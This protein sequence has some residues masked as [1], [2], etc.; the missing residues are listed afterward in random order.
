MFYAYY[1]SYIEYRIKN[2]TV[3]FLSLRFCTA[4]INLK[5]LYKGKFFN[6]KHKEHAI[7]RSIPFPGKLG[8]VIHPPICQ[9]L[10][11]GSTPL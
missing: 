2:Y 5:F 4:K 11:Q 6:I 8:W 9:P 10:R 7:G 1:L 3:L